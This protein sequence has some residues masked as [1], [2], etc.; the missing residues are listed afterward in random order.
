MIVVIVALSWQAEKS[1]LLI[2]AN[3]LLFE[4]ITYLCGFCFVFFTSFLLCSFGTSP[5]RCFRSF[6]GFIYFFFFLARAFALPLA[7]TPFLTFL[8]LSSGPCP[9]HPSPSTWSL[10]YSRNFIYDLHSNIF[11]ILDQIQSISHWLTEEIASTRYTN[12]RTLTHLKINTFY[13]DHLA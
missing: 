4:R 11:L 3:S 6:C 5:F 1:F 12:T 10:I 7:C 8:I 2:I 13:T 9:S